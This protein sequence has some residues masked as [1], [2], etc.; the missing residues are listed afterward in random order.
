MGLEAALALRSV[1]QKVGLQIVALRGA[2]GGPVLGV[3]VCVIPVAALLPE[4][5]LLA[6]AQALQQKNQMVNPAMQV[7][8]A[9][10]DTVPTKHAAQQDIADIVEPATAKAKAQLS[11]ESQRLVMVATGRLPAVQVEAHRKIRTN[12]LEKTKMS[13]PERIKMNLLRKLTL[14]FFVV[15]LANL[16]LSLIMIRVLSPSS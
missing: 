13:Y 10:R 6:E 2:A 5:A 12:L 16:R 11:Q 14:F 7:Q 15:T 3:Y 4:K 8:N 1:F 9:L